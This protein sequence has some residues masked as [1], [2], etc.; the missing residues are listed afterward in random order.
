MFY[1]PT[2]RYN[3]KLYWSNQYIFYLLKHTTPT[4]GVTIIQCISN[5]E[6]QNDTAYVSIRHI[7]LQNISVMSVH[8]CVCAILACHVDSEFD[9]SL[10][11]ECFLIS[12]FLH[13]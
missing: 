1:S 2:R 3:R 5:M 9:F 8:T 10:N 13:E 11:L 4:D 7:K 12:T 6:I